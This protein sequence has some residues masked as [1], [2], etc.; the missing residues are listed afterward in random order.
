MAWQNTNLTPL[1]REIKHKLIDRGM[2]QRQLAAALGIAPQY[3][4]KI[5]SGQRSGERYILKICTMLDININE[6]TAA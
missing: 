4:T 2:T 5:L 6:Y 1:G 3:I